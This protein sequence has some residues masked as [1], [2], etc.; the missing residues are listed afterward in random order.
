MRRPQGHGVLFDPG[1]DRAVEEHDTFTCSHCQ[2]IVKVPA[3]CD[4]AEMGGMCRSCDG[5]ICPRCH[6]A[7]AKGSSCVTWEETMRRM[8]ARQDALRSYGL[9]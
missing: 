2:S 3:R 5:L 1:S 9:A 7:M 6:D 4:P 8:M